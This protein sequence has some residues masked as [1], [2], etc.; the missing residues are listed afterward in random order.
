MS[1]MWRADPCEDQKVSLVAEDEF[2]SVPS[3]FWKRLLWDVEQ[4]Q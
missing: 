2:H 3:S 4:S 1:P